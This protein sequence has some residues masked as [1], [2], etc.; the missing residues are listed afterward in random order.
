MGINPGDR[1]AQRAW[2][3]AQEHHDW[4]HTE[5]LLRLGR[6][7]ADPTRL[8]LLGVLADKSLYGQE[9]ADVLGVTAPTVSRHLTI[10]KA[11]GLVR[12][13]RDQGYHYYAL[14]PDGLRH[15]AALL[16]VDTLRRLAGADLS[17][18]SLPPP[19]AADEQALALDSYVR[20]GV[21]LSIPRDT[22]AR[23]LV[24]AWVARVFTPER[25]YTEA[26]VNA[27]LRPLYEDV[28]SLRR[29]LVDADLM[30]RAAGRYWLTGADPREH[31]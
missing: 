19:T 31:D 24:L 15:S 14:D 22:T 1:E 13:Q 20:D 3:L 10:L 25:Q 21:L 5:P 6:A 27:L 4:A 29:A 9:L 16:S 30:A 2:S 17:T 23:R 12:V 8:R 18:A 7:L 11:A 28:A 26:E